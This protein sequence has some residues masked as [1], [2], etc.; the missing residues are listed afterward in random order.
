MTDGNCITGFS[1]V[2]GSGSHKLEVQLWLPLIS[3]CIKYFD[4]AEG[5][6]AGQMQQF[7]IFSSTAPMLAAGCNVVANV[8][9]ITL[10]TRVFVL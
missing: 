7:C 3:S 1:V 6:C 2:L 5:A 10:I 9:N 4:A 8:S